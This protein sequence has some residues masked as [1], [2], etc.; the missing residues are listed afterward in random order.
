MFSV[1]MYTTTDQTT[2]MNVAAARHHKIT[3][4]A[5]QRSAAQQ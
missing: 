4:T 2:T 3:E 1:T 5:L